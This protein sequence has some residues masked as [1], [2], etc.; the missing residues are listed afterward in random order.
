MMCSSVHFYGVQ[1]SE[2][3][4]G[5]VQLRAVILA[6]DQCSAMGQ[7]TVVQCYAWQFSVVLW[8][9]VQCSTMGRSSV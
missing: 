5:A 8:G 2:V 9:A 1:F 3:V 4:W 7:F 6:A